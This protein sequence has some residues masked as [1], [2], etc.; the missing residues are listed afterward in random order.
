VENLW[1]DSF[2]NIIVD[3]DNLEFLQ[4]RKVCFLKSGDAVV[5]D[6][7]VGGVFADI[8][9]YRCERGVPAC[10]CFESARTRI[11][12]GG[13]RSD[14][15]DEKDGSDQDPRLLVDHISCKM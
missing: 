2:N 6:A 11:G 15:D 12:A 3:G 5:G 1:F 10:G 4:I 8:M 7:E 13:Q 14:P 9:W